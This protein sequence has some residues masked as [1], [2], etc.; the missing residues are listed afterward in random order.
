M[1][2][3]KFNVTNVKS[4]MSVIE[5]FFVEFKST[6]NEIDSIILNNINESIASSVF[7]KLGGKL[8]N[9]WYYNSSNFV[10]FHDHFDEWAAA[11]A[12]VTANNEQFSIDTISTY[13]KNNVPVKNSTNNIVFSSNSADDYVVKSIDVKKN[14]IYGGKTVTFL[15]ASGI[16]TSVFYGKDGKLI[17]KKITNKNGEETILSNGGEKIDILP[18]INVNELARD[19]FIKDIITVARMQIGVPFVSMNYGPKGSLDEGFGSAMFV[20]YCYNEVLFDRVSGNDPNNKGFYGSAMNFWGNV[21]KDGF[22]AH[23]RGFVEVSAEDALPTDIVCFVEKGKTGD[24]YSE[25]SNCFHIGLYE[26]DGMIIHSSKY[27]TNGVGE[28]KIDDYLKNREKECAV[29]YLRY[30]GPGVETVEN[31]N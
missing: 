25:A 29:K 20:S 22:D 30:V 19:K 24:Y 1:A 6:L 10:S 27:V 12:K 17:A 13:Q 16:L 5:N 26:G 3:E 21:T 15:S 18:A 28:C 2:D 14:N 9:I 11:V 31:S 7:G 23:N 4:K 8:I